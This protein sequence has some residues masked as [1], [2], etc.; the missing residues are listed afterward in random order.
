MG[1][2][3]LDRAREARINDEVVVDAYTAEERCMSWWYFVSERCRFP[4]HARC[5]RQRAI[6]PL[7]KGEDVEVL[8]IAPE[9]ECGLELF[10]VIHWSGRRFAVPLDQLVPIAADHETSEA[11]QDW[12]YWVQRGYRF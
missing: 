10:V 9:T 7:V 2:S 4:F 5:D 11:V 1:R 12:R 3:N 6:S 8:S